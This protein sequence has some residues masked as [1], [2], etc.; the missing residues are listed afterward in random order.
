MQAVETLFHELGC[1]DAD[2]A[3]LLRDT[4]ITPTT[5]MPHLGAF[6]ATPSARPAMHMFLPTPAGVPHSGLI[7]QRTHELLQQYATLMPRRNGRSVAATTA[8]S[9]G[10]GPSVPTGTVRLVVPPPRLDD[11]DDDSALADNRPLT[12]T[13]LH[14]MMYNSAAFAA[15][16]QAISSGSPRAPAAR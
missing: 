14:G 8:V 7:E 15:I 10:Q 3:D 6:E 11:F 1:D 9:L 2:G 5:L 13:E 16:K 12:R 4:G